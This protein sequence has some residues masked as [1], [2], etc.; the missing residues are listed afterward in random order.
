MED[1]PDARPPIELPEGR[2][3]AVTWSIP[4]RFGGMTSALLHRSRA[5]VRL[6]GREVDIVTFDDRPDYEAVRARLVEAGELIPGI[7]LHNLHED[8]RDGRFSGEWPTRWDSYA[9]WLDTLIGDE[10]AFAVVDSKTVARFMARYRRPNVVTAHVVHNS[11]LV[12]G[13][14]PLGLLRPSRRS[15]FAHLERF[16]AVVFLTERQ[17]AD[18]AALLSDPGNLEV[19]PNGIDLPADAGDTADDDRDPTAGVVVAALTERKRID[20][21]IDIVAARRDAGAPVSLT[22]YGEGPD[23]DALVDRVAHAGLE[24]AVTFA[25]HRENA[26][27]AFRHASWTLLTSTFEGAPL[28]LA[29]AM[30]RGCL[31]IAYDIA[32]G[33][34]DLIDD[35]VD[36]FLVPDGGRAAAADAI[37]RLAALPAEEQR[38]MRQ[39]ARRA[40]ARHDD[41]AVVAEWSRVLADAAERHA[42]PAPSLDA[43]VEKVRLRFRGGRLLV[44]ARLRGVPHGARVA[45]SLR[46]RATEA[47][48]QTRMPAREGRLA[49]RVD[50][51]RTRLVGGRHPLVCDIALEVDGA[52]QEF[53]PVRA[54][55][56]ARS[57]VR[58]AASR[59]SRLLHPGVRERSTPRS[60]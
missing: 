8:L 24:H 39:A 7:R 28:V 59:V 12:T 32:Y 38:R 37:G 41:E 27:D 42:R 1:T 18:A 11:H 56:D 5:F 15:V 31:P 4:D 36:G 53:P 20:H 46:H 60:Q 30:A 48:V 3:L 23:A 45:I 35:G 52:R 33:P 6:A 50:A 14:R 26:A 17:R 10:P 34:A 16:D 55:P 19:A 54:F 21:A 29:E 13:E 47:L 2:Q 25:G 40:A 44:S 57:P 49:W 51:D 58:R 22:I 43:S 9:D